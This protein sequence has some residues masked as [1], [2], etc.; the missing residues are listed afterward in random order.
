MRRCEPPPVEPFDGS[1]RPWLLAVARTR[2]M[3]T[4]SEDRRWGRAAE[5]ADATVGPDPAEA[6]ARGLDAGPE[7]RRVLDAVDGLPAELRDPLVLRVWG[8]LSHVEIAESLGIAV[9]TVKS[10]LNR[11]RRRLAP[12]RRAVEAT[13]SPLR[14]LSLCSPAPTTPE[15]HP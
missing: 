13:P 15:V 3:R 4:W 1:L 7:L 9:G 2:A 14:R 6:V 5:R 11:A 8:E 12:A 10:R